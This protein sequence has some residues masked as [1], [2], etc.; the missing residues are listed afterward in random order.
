MKIKITYPESWAD[1]KLSQYL[2][3]YKVVKPYVDTEDYD[4]ISLET[5]A[6][7]FCEVPAE[8]LYKLP[9]TTLN[10]IKSTIH[11]L[12][13]TNKLPLVR[14]FTVGET[15]YG[16]IPELDS[17]AYG[18]YLDLVAY[19]KDTWTNLPIIFSI[20]Y[21]PVVKQL[22]NTYTISPYNGTEDSRIELFNHTL[23]MDVVFGAISF[24]LDLQIDLLNS[25]L[26]YSVETLK[27]STDPQVLAVLEDLEK[28]GTDIT[29]LQSLLTTTLPSSTK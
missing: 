22:G 8:H 1:I 20:L 26:L 2:R 11:N 3:Y 10:K 21:R 14:K 25:T 9:E 12:T 17:M 16:F 29:Q 15:T 5:A 6:L 13:S 27:K 18:E 19:F 24:F 28:N 23:T 7:H 4:K